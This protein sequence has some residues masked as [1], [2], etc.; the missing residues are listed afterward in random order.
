MIL[1]HAL[2]TVRFLFCFSLYGFVLVLAMPP[3]YGCSPSRICLTSS[4]LSS[5]RTTGKLPGPTSWQNPPFPWHVALSPHTRA[6]KV[7]ESTTFSILI[8]NAPVNVKGRSKIVRLL[9][10]TYVCCG[11]SVEK[12]THPKEYFIKIPA[13]LTPILA[14]GIFFSACG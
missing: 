4:L 9:P 11:N 5:G 6:N 2:S 10:P 12:G 3:A 7:W 14:P 8:Q 1:Y 13:N